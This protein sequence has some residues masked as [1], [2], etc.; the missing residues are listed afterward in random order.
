M[1]GWYLKALEILDRFL[2]KHGLPVLMSLVLVFV[3][4]RSN[5]STAK[6]LAEHVES[7]SSAMSTIAQ[8]NLKRAEHDR[9]IEDLAGRNLM[10]NEKILNALLAI[11]VQSSDIGER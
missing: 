8:D 2:D 6:A 3:L 7:T 10:M 1:P 5:E 11:C 9:N 4:V